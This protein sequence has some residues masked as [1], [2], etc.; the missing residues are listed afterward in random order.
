M[1]QNI[2]NRYNLRRK[3]IV[4]VLSIVLL[5]GTIS[6]V[7][8]STLDG[9]TLFN[10]GYASLDSSDHSADSGDQ[11]T[12]SNDDGKENEDGNGNN[13]DTSSESN[14]QELKQQNKCS[15]GEVLNE[16][17][18]KCEE[19]KDDDNSKDQEE[20]IDSTD[21]DLCLKIR[22]QIARATSQKELDS[23]S[24][25][26][27]CLA[28]KNKGAEPSIDSEKKQVESE[29]KE[30]SSSSESTS[31]EK[32]K[33]DGDSDKSDSKTKIQS[34]ECIDYSTLALA[35]LGEVTVKQCLGEED[36]E[37]YLGPLS[38]GK[39]ENQLSEIEQFEK[40]YTLAFSIVSFAM[41]GNT[42]GQDL[43][44]K[45]MDAP[46]QKPAEVLGFLYGLEAAIVAHDIMVEE[47][48][49]QKDTLEALG[50]QSNQ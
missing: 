24:I 38:D 29:N 19:I 37:K 46:D 48:K 44:K 32:S 5:F 10:F 45:I 28:S 3:S 13:G 6:S 17:T 40:F 18:G 1:A 39:V 31:A 9:V 11:S 30:S 12:A 43:V 49:L 47:A 22:G 36:L 27:Q 41:K 2:D 26:E 8:N 50:V 20:P 21:P 42:I 14:S 25:P 15:N 35:A 33:F 7:A 16:E 23:I 4:L 34:N